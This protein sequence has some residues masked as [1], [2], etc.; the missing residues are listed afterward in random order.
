M[1][2]KAAM[3]QDNFK[4]TADHLKKLVPLLMKYHIPATPSNYALWYTYVSCSDKALNQ[5]IDES[6]ESSGTF[7][8]EQCDQLYQQHFADKKTDEISHFE[9]TLQSLAIEMSST[10]EDTLKDT[11]VFQSAL[12][13]TFSQL[14]RVSDENLSIEETLNVVQH[15]AKGSN[16]LK[17]STDF[18]KNQLSEAQK[19]ISRLKETLNRAN[20]KAN[21]DALTGLLNRGAFDEELKILTSSQPFK[22]F[23]LLLCDLDHFKNF[24]DTYGHLK[25]DQVLKLTASRLFEHNQNNTKA[26]RYGGEEFALLVPNSTLAIGCNTGEMVRASIDKLALKDKKTRKTLDNISI[27]VGVALYQQGESI[28]SLIKRADDQ[29]YEAKNKGRNCVMPAISA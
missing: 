2:K 3:S 4:Q 14:A 26:F 1:E 6:I 17:Q 8:K 5:K 22:P 15:L 21:H 13:D 19:E 18:F 24:N 27:S 25:G 7:T 29:L 16:A 10:M 9:K 20:E 23:C 28:E 12:D 11:H